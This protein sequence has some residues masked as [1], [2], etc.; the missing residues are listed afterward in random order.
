MSGEPENAPLGRGFRKRKQPSDPV[1]TAV[2]IMKEK[3]RYHALAKSILRSDF[4]DDFKAEVPNGTIISSRPQ[5]NDSLSW[6]NDDLNT[7]KP[8]MLEDILNISGIHVPSDDESS[9]LNFLADNFNQEEFEKFMA[10]MENFRDGSS[11]GTEQFPSPHAVGRASGKSQSLLNPGSFSNGQ[12]PSK[13]QVSIPLKPLPPDPNSPMALMAMFMKQQA[14][15]QR[16]QAELTRQNM[17]ANQR[18]MN[19][20]LARMTQQMN[21]QSQNMLKLVL[22][23]DGGQKSVAGNRSAQVSDKSS[24]SASGMLAATCDSLADLSLKVDDT[25]SFLLATLVGALIEKNVLLVAQGAEDAIKNAL[26][27]VSESDVTVEQAFA[28]KLLVRDHVRDCQDAITGSTATETS[29]KQPFSKRVQA[30]QQQQQSSAR[31]R[32]FRFP[33]IPGICARYNEEGRCQNG[34]CTY[35]HSCVLCFQLKNKQHVS[36]SALYCDSLR[37]QQ[38]DGNSSQQSGSVGSAAGQFSVD[39]LQQALSKLM[40]QK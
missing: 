9:G 23:K 37:P 4:D 13:L 2:K 25:N 26:Q 14:E 16:Q 33:L 18:A 29:N 38:F 28:A 31:S 35:T 17:E 12:D 39:N 19:E 32:D 15:Q 40:G 34:R 20:N 10:E 7:E 5:S 3:A 24:L 30:P 21:E 22:E 1:A 27:R 8:L 36:H 6:D 11:I